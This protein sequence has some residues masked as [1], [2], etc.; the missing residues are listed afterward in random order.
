MESTL[1]RRWIEPAI[2]QVPESLSAAVGGHPLV[3]RLLYERGLHT[4]QT[5]LAFL[6]PALYQASSPLD[7]PG[8]EA[9]ASRIL[10]A[11]QTGE[12]ICV[13][14][15]FDVD[16]QTATTLLVGTLRDLGAQ[17]TF[18]IPLRERESHGVNLEVLQEL[19]AL[20]NF[21]LVLTCDTGIAA[22]AA[23]D[24]AN[25]IGLD[26]V[27]TDHHELP[28]QL[29]AAYAILN[30]RL[31]PPDHPAT[32]LPG[33]GA[34]YQL[35]AELFQR[36]GQPEA[37]DQHLDLVALGIVADV[38][39]LH[40]EARYLL[41]RGLV[42]L[43]KAARPGLMAM[44]EMAD[45]EAGGITEEHISFVIA[46][47][48]NALGRLS[49]ANPIVEF[50]TTQDMG[51][52]RILAN[53]LE[54][55]NAHRKL[56]TEQV[57]QAAQAQLKQDPALLDQPAIVLSHPTWPAGV[58]GIVAS[59]LVERY[60]R[61]AILISTPPG[62]AARGSARSVEGCNIT[63]AI[64]AQSPILLGFGG[65]AM[66]AGLSLEVERI[67]D[68]K[69]GLQ[70]SLSE[71]LG[72]E[73]AQPTLLI[74][75][76]LPLAEL[77]PEL[78]ADFERLAP[79]GQG[80]PPLTLASPGLRLRSRST[81]GRGDEHLQLIVEDEGNNTYKL[82]WWQG[83]SW[84]LP[85]AA[86]EGQPFDLAYH[87]RM[88]NYRGLRQLQVEFVDLRLV[89][90]VEQI[91]VSAKKPVQVIDLRGQSHPRARLER[92]LQNE[93]PQIWAE[94]QAVQLL[95]QA[96]ISSLDRYHLSPSS[97]LVIWTTPP[98][99]QELASTL[100]VVSPDRVYLFAIQ[101]EETK[102][103][104]F[105]QRLAGL[106]K[107]ALSTKEGRLDL[108]DLAAATAQREATLRK[109][110]AWLEA[111]GHIRIL[112]E[113]GSLL[114]ISPGEGKAQPA[115]GEIEGQLRSMLNETAAYRAYF[116]RAAA[117]GVVHIE[118]ST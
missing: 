46:P 20:H 102:P 62:Q 61:P 55:L 40:G 57:F 66:A 11:I 64:A 94:G 42:A 58:I 2:K 34:A 43:R 41:Q 88:G 95:A 16:G 23:I 107:Y 116:A 70:L 111:A 31:L 73:P 17:V 52:A 32:T 49:D 35:A 103:A 3:A 97:S 50:F 1:S 10:Q 7:W 86:L 24:Y 74:D 118:N 91:Q 44:L 18:H 78:V 77:T 104:E 101:P 87:V 85:E 5:A 9:A 63:Q 75:G 54:G 25:S 115:T 21:G 48:L 39:A 30:P 59:R 12:R 83:A 53:Q 29:P 76:N 6:N 71:T 51:R 65:H 13:W 117:S 93:A 114:S 33:V 90:T 69:R 56:L 96:S 81:I 67:P 27:V 105:M 8:M 38:A 22:H 82:I 80:N 45:L 15:D 110:L 36:A 4:P 108:L 26:F 79:F 47:R 100:Q 109:G 68:F 72:T 14:G 60:N 112:E 106:V 37:V 92:I 28:A 99:R 98:G 84:E 19:H 89:P 113:A